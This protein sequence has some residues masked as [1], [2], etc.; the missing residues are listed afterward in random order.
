MSRV[1]GKPYFVYVLWSEGGRRF[2]VGVSE[3]PEVRL[4]QHN[5]GGRG[6]TSRYAPWRLVYT[7]PHRDYQAARKR[8]LQLKA[9]KRGRGFWTA[10]RLDPAQ[11]FTGSLGS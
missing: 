6:W 10:T 9:Q 7:E 1:S 11:F 4:Q 2:Y 8:E 3:D 5:H